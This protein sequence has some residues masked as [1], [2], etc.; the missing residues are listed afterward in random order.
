M[1][2][3]EVRLID[4]HCHLDH[5]YGD[6]SA[7]V[8]AREAAEAGV[9]Q[10][11]TVGTSPD[12][13]RRALTLSDNL[14]GVYFTA[15]VHPHAAGEM[16]DRHL[17]E[18][19]IA[20]A[21]PRCGAVGEIGL[22]YHYD[23]SPRSIQRER[24]ADQLKLALAVGLPVVIHG[25]EAEDDLMEALNW[26]TTLLPPTRSPGVLHCFS[27]PRQLGAACLKL[28]FYISFSGMLTYKW[29]DEIRACARDFPL[30]RL[31][32]ETDAPYLAPAPHRGKR[33][34]PRMVRHTA[35]RLAELRGISEQ[36]VARATTENARRL[37]SRERP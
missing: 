33:C 30:N 34:E 25:R 24:L 27:G 29:A 22:D 15:G 11:V 5:D 2:E 6:K 9:E 23:Y 17:G 14:P 10:L 4:S 35:Q 26:Y 7:A 19:M 36:E 13:V 8:L 12:S 18:L 28:G 1:L 3:H 21:H 31:L 37:F 20:A 16:E 32:V